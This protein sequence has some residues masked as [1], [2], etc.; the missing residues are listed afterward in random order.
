LR[1]VE[2]FQPRHAK[3]AIRMVL[4]LVTR[5]EDWVENLKL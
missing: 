3:G 5:P 1:S 2:E 4:D